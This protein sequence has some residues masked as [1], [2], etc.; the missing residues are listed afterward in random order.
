MAVQF[1]INGT[2]VNAPDFE[3]IAW[4]RMHPPDVSLTGRL[5]F[6]D[7]LRAILT[8]TVMHDYDLSAIMELWA[9]LEADGYRCDGVTLP[10]VISG[11]N[12]E[13]VDYVGGPSTGGKI[14]VHWPEGSREVIQGS[15]VT[16]IF[17]HLKR[18]DVP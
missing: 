7:G 18:P 11:L 4:Q 13:W 6:Q 15:D 12:S 16:M 14:T 5:T 3:K 9:A 1:K 17:E 8:W 10:P 2:L